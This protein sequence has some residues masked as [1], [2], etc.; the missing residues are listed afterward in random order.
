MPPA[1]DPQ[2]KKL[3]GAIVSGYQ[4]EKIILFGSRAT[5][6]SEP[7]SDIDLLIIKDTSDSYWN[8]IKSL[9]PFLP[10]TP[11]IDVFVATPQE[12]DRA[13]SDNRFFLTREILPKS[14]VLYDKSAAS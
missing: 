12:Y 1:L 2:I 5:G 6:R 11:S 14:V 9:A 10:L 7:D 13:V 4:P 3:T 8:R